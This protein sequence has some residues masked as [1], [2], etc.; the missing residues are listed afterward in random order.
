MPIMRYK[1]IIA[2]VLALAVFAPIAVFEVS[3]RREDR[4]N[5]RRIERRIDRRDNKRI[6]IRMERNRGRNHSRAIS[7]LSPALFESR[8]V[9]AKSLSS[10]ALLSSHSYSKA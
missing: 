7:R 1:K 8:A 10:T 6:E 4:R 3:A 9:I 5:D 2:G